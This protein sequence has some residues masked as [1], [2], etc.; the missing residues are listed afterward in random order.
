MR[1]DA[2]QEAAQEAYRQIP[3]EYKTGID[4]LRVAREALPHPTAPDVYTLG[5]C[6][7]EA[8]PSDWEGPDTTRSI[9]V[10]YWGSFRRL[11]E[12]DP[13]LDWEEELW[14]TLTHELRH[15]L[16]WLAQEEGLEGV[17]YAMEEEFKRWEGEPFD[18][19]YF[20]QGDRVA[21]GV[22]RVERRF[23]VEQMWDEES[24]READRIRFDWRGHTY[25]VPRPKELGDVHFV[26]PEGLDARP[27]EPDQPA[28]TDET[29]D[30]DQPAESVELVLVRKVGWWEQV[31]G[32]FTGRRPKVLQS[33]GRIREVRE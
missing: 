2:F 26:W 21:E 10:L 33:V 19:W 11:S 9:V 25:D 31:K 3:D 16:E 28:E 30:P 17:D 4:G 24:F 14:E 29:A 18:P 22:Y 13:T 32:L 8:Y 6:V 15:H 7:T 12:L 20:Q 23:Y 5:E 1:F 27:S